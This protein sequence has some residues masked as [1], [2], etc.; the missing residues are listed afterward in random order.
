M[1]DSLAMFEGH[2]NRIC[3]GISSVYIIKRVNSVQGGCFLAELLNGLLS[4][5]LAQK[6]TTLR[7]VEARRGCIV[8]RHGALVDGVDSDNR[9]E[10]PSSP[11]PSAPWQSSTIPVCV[12]LGT[13]V[14]VCEALV[15]MKILSGREISVLRR[16]GGEYVS[17]GGYGKLLPLPGQRWHQERQI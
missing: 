1:A 15:H 3:L 16:V 4:R 17:V 10:A 5:R 12:P 8:K 7:G 6:K 14:R 2:V 11:L 13:Q 9:T